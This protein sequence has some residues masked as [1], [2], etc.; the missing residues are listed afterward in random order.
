[1]SFTRHLIIGSALLL[2]GLFVTGAQLFL[3]AGSTPAVNLAVNLPLAAGE[4]LDP[5]AAVAAVTPDRGSFITAMKQALSERITLSVA[6]VD[7]SAV[8]L[9]NNKPTADNE[10][11]STSTKRTVF[12]CDATVLE[13]QFAAAWPS[14]VSVLERE[15]A[16]VVVNDDAVPAP[17]AG[18]VTA[19]LTLMQFAL[20]PPLRSEPA[21]LTSGYVGVTADGR[22]IHNND[23][24][25]YQT[26]GANTLV[27]YAFDGNPIYGSVDGS[28]LDSCGGQ[29][30]ANGYQY[31]LRSGENFILGCFMSEPQQSVLAG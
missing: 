15:G 24:I 22:L 17:A 30:T 25:L 18:T 4:I 11:A 23:V 28:S 31:N 14:R 20:V 2:I 26:Y 8:E 29:K 12:W 5:E 6:A 21:C 10:G 19:P 1:M 16:R 3:H 13:A 9:E 27:G 7:E